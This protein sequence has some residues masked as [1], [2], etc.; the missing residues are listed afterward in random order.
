MWKLYSGAEYSVLL[1]MNSSTDCTHI[2]HTQCTVSGQYCAKCTDLCTQ[3][4]NL[5]LQLA[6]SEQKFIKLRPYYN[7]GFPVCLCSLFNILKARQAK[8]RDTMHFPLYFI[9][10]VILH[11]PPFSSHIVSFE[12][13]G[14]S[15]II[16]L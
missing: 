10:A 7:T 16:S 14:C 2:V 13:T 6:Y 11:S 3:T 8:L 4:R 15:V 12:G 5:V 9:S 1:P